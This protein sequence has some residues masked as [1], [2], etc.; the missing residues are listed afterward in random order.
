[1]ISRLFG[2]R[3]VDQ[4]PALRRY[5]RSLTRDETAADDLVHDA[6]L[7]AC[8]RH[9]SFRPGASLRAWLMS[10]VHNS[11]IDSLRRE[12]SQKRRIEGAALVA[13]TVDPGGQEAAVRLAAVARAFNA[14]PDEQRAVLHLVAIEG[15]SY[16][17]AAVALDV[18]VGTIMS[19][20]SRA[21]AALRAGETLP[22]PVTRLRAV[23]DPDAQA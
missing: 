13:A 7:R 15:L 4:V 3:I 5:A 10:I 21:R 20:L 17:E 12:A 2:H 6:L 1:M 11:F 18:P 22:A 14:L 16:A 8:E 9:K 23:G 19:R